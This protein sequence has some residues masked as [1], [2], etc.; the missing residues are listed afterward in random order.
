V[1]RRISLRRITATTLAVA[2]LGL[3][4]SAIGAPSA[5]AAPE[6]PKPAADLV[7]DAGTG[8]IIVCDS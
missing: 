2:T 1:S 6:L 3:F 5:G 7:V 8:R 4:G